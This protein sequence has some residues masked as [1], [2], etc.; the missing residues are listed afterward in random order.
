MFTSSALEIRSQRTRT[1]SLATLSLSYFMVL[2]DSTVLNVALPAIEKQLHGS[3]ASLQ[4]VANSYTLVFASFL[5]SSGTIGDRYGVRRTFRL[6]LG[7]FT[8]ASLFCSLAPTIEI[9]ISAR[10]IQGLGAALMVPASLSL[11]AHLFTEPREQAK[12][13]AVWAGIGSI[14]VGL[15]PTLGGLLVEFL[16]WRSV[17]VINVPLGILALVLSFFCLPATPVRRESGLDLPGQTLAIIACC[18]LT[19]GL[20][21]WG[22][23]PLRWLIAAFA[24]ALI[25][26]CAFIVVEKRRAHPM[27]PLHL[28]RSWRVSATMLIGLVY[29][30]S[31]YSLFFVFS[32][33]FQQYYG[34]QA[35]E[36]GLAFMPQTITGSALIL[37]GTRWIMLWFR[38]R[39]ALAIGM[40]L[41]ALGMLVIFIGMRT[42]FFVIALGEVLVGA[43][44]SFIV[45]PMTTVIL[46]SVGKE[47]SGIASASLNTTR[48]MGGVL[49]VAILG[50]VLGSQALFI[51]TEKAVFIMLGFFLLGLVLILSSG[52]QEEGAH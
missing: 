20:I 30:F 31:F 23:S 27:L 12:A 48:Q 7:I 13:V 35:L 49:G 2:L 41:G 22:H 14:A 16:G 33:F 3:V 37:F 38:P 40:L 4:W 32:L 1:I 51:G 52:R 6:G 45:T 42:D 44:A 8:T 34:F 46:A 28:F 43:T 50:T 25:S 29:Q 5:L 47:Q 39:T 24:L 17:F 18:T 21:E 19:Y 9:L 36:A 11:I 26:G 10:V 15:G